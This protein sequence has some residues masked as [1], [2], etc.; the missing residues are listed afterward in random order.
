MTISMFDAHMIRSKAVRALRMMD[1]GQSTIYAQVTEDGRT[2]MWNAWTQAITEATRA[3]V[4]SAL[5]WN[6]Q[7]ISVANLKAMFGNLFG[8]RSVE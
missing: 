7:K 3:V 8:K 6:G 5:T 2:K 1:M 4:D